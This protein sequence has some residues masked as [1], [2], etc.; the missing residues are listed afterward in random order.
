MD[1][2]VTKTGA[3]TP[4]AAYA[5][6]GDS[7]RD[8][9]LQAASDLFCRFGI[10]ATGVDAIVDRAGTAK[11]TLYKTF[12]SKEGLVEA[13]LEAEGASWR[14]WFLTE[15]ERVRGGPADKIV[16]IFSILERWFGEERFFGC[17]FINAVGEN[18]KR[19]DRYR[20]I[21]LAHKMIVMARIEALVR[22]AGAA[23]PARTA[24]EIG[25]LIDGAIVAAMITRDAKVARHAKSAARKI[26]AEIE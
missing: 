9:I 8:R 20:R 24:H 6:T 1:T 2:V 5:P 15:L 19:D 12:G 4:H 18:D 10:N 13:V 17:P 23:Q 21:A 7:A 3:R 16:G 25:V 14:H 26:L 22:E 11:A